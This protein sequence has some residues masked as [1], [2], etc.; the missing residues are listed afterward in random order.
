MNKA[1]NAPFSAQAL[2]GAQ[3]MDAC[4][5]GVMA[6]QRPVLIV[7]DLDGTLTDSFELGRALFKRVFALMGMGEI[8]DALADS[9]NGPSADE[10]CRIMGV[11]KDRRALYD[12]LIDEVEPQLVREIGKVYPGVHEMLLQLSRCAV[13]AILT[14]GAPVYCQACMETY[15]FAPYIALHSG[16]AAGVTK[17]QRIAQWERETSARRVI[18]VGD[19]KT[20]ID[21]A[22]QAGAYAVGVTYGMGSREE[23]MQADALCDTP[24]QVTQACMRVMNEV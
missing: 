18:V 14:N 4:C 11:G 19:R 15:G 2:T 23:L 13:L 20:D 22:R 7:F 3:A 1:L 9:F 8:S 17:A 21:N 6:M 12:A 16:Y 10:V 5:S 24:Q